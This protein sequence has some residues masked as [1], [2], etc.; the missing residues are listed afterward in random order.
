MNKALLWTARV[1]C[2]IVCFGLA[3]SLLHATPISGLTVA[4]S[5]DGQSLIA[6]GSNRVFYRVDPQTL[7]V[8]ER[9]WNGLSITAMA[10]DR[11]GSVLAVTDGGMGGYVTMFDVATLSKKKELTGLEQV[12]FCTPADLLAGVD[13][14]R[15]DPT[16]L[17]VAKL[18]DGSVVMTATLQ[19]KRPVA[20]VGLD[21]EGSMVA[22]LYEGQNDATEEKSTPAPALKGLER[23][24]AQQQMDGRTSDVAFF[25]IPSGEKIA[26]HKVYFTSSGTASAAIVDGRLVVVTYQNQ[27]AAIGQD[28]AVE[29]FACENSFNYGIGFSSDHKLIMTGG[30]ADMSLTSTQD[31]SSKKIGVSK[32]LPS[33]PEYFKGFAAGSE[34][35]CFGASDGYRLFVIQR[36]GSVALEKPVF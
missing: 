17:K 30:L 22:V 20:A 19:P 9:V 23:V 34:G 8:G 27:N 35:V 2:T 18:G 25:R 10:F 4:R 31:W 3:S 16:T 15:R 12:A 7:E 6:A 26:E 14:N 1:G 24:M 28:G 29:M 11:S 33:W 32:K 36:D 21:L 5:P 13:G